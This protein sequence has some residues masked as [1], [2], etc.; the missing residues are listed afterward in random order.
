M[1]TG[2]EFLKEHIEETNIPAE[3]LEVE[4]GDIMERY[5][6][7]YH[8]N[9]KTIDIKTKYKKEKELFT[10]WWEKITAKSNKR[11]SLERMAAHEAW[12]EAK[13]VFK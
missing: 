6:D 8:Q 1:K 2:R 12:M 4:I 5:A 9:L 3:H 11:T 10:K 7:Y 13:A